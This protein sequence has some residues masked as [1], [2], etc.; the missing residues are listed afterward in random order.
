M[1]GRTSAV[2]QL[3]GMGRRGHLRT[4]LAH[5]GEPNRISNM[6]ET[7]TTNLQ[8]PGKVVAKKVWTNCKN[9]QEKL[10]CEQNGAF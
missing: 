6:D 1:R 4:L 7:D 9:M 3:S 10:R 5:F 2:R 8:K